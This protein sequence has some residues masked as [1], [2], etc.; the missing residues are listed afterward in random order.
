MGLVGLLPCQKGLR[1]LIFQSL[2]KTK[3]QIKLFLKDTKP[4]LEIVNM[5]KNEFKNQ[6]FIIKFFIAKLFGRPS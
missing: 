6:A 5:C 4:I 1:Y 3:V 2:R